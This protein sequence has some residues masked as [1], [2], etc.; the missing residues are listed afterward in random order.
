[1]A[2]Q[3]SSEVENGLV[4]DAKDDRMPHFCAYAITSE[5]TDLVTRLL[6]Y[7]A[8]SKLKN[9]NYVDPRCMEKRLLQSDRRHLHASW[10]GALCHMH[11]PE[12]DEARRGRGGRGDGRTEEN[13]VQ[14][15]LIW[16]SANRIL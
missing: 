13:R 1:M 2:I 10:C 14:Q 5:D 9:S 15:V 12:G 8:E 7:F 3:H 16:Y 6:T 4:E 11:L